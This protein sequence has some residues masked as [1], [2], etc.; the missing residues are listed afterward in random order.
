MQGVMGRDDEG[1]RGAGGR[2]DG[3]G[4]EGLGPDEEEGAADAEPVRAEHAV[5]GGVHDEGGEQPGTEQEGERVQQGKG[6]Q[7]QAKQEGKR[8]QR[9]GQR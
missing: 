9:G 1:R 7:G 2:G 8:L 3:S 4:E 5:E 6:E